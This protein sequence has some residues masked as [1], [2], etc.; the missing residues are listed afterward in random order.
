MEQSVAK[1]LTEISALEQERKGLA[2]KLAKAEE[3]I[4]SLKNEHVDA[5]LVEKNGVSKVFTTQTADQTYRLFIE[6]MSEGA[7]T[8]SADGIILYSNL[9]FSRMVDT[10]LEAIIGADFHEFIPAEDK[11]NFE[12]FFKN[13]WENDTR[14][15]LT[16]SGH[17]SHVIPVTL[18]LTL[19]KVQDSLALSVIVTD[20]TKQKEEEKELKIKN[21]LLKSANADLSGFAYIASHDL[22]E[23]LRTIINYVGLFQKKYKENPDENSE[24]Y[25]SYIKEATARMQALIHDLLEYS[26]IGRHN[27]RMTQIDCN[28]LL[29]I[30]LKDLSEAIREGNAKIRSGK[31]PVVKGYYIEIRSLFQNL[32]ANAVKF[33]KNGIQPIIDITVKD[34]KSEWLFSVKDNGIGI[35]AIYNE[36]IFTVFQRLHTLREFPGTGIGLAHCKKIVELHKGKIWVESKLGKGSCFYFTIPKQLPD[37]E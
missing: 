11:Q 32:I 27:V 29:E 35:E 9:R 20:L 3:Y 24:S 31:L 25:L 23:P 8:L 22:Q 12:E 30:V 33:R 18:S 4:E 13:A 26:R 15:E 10:P 5:F 21:Q 2:G 19:L 1:L 6:K 37:E 28:E 17:G 7:V 16:I 36:R 34:Q 14:G